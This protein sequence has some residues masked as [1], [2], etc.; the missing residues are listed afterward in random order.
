MRVRSLIVH[1]NEQEGDG[2]EEEC[3]RGGHESAGNI[4]GDGGVAEAGERQHQKELQGRL[5]VFSDLA[6]KWACMRLHCF[7]ILP[8]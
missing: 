6:N 3:D 1:Y 2:R 8:L 7:P 5:P 4:G